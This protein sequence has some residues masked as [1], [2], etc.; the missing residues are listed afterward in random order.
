[1]ASAQAASEGITINPQ[2]F[3]PEGPLADGE[4][5]YYAEMG[6][7]RVMR[8][9]GNANRLIWSRPGC[10]PTSV[11]RAGRDLIVLCHIEE[12]LVRISVA[13]ETLQVI[14]RDRDGRPFMTPNASVNDRKGG[15]YFSSS[16]LF[17]SAAP[18]QGAVL[19]LDSSGRLS[20]LAEGV[21]YSNGVALTPDGGTLYVSEHLS[22]R[23][24]AYDVAGDGRLFGRRVFVALD[25]LVGPEDGRGWEV[26]PDGLAVD[27]AGNV[28][29]AEYGAGRLLIVDRRGGLLATV[30]VPERYVTAPALTPDETRIYLTAPASLFDPAEAGRVYAIANPVHRSQ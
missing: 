5:V 16:G 4:G 7:D 21:R 29:V 8:W 19:Y 15:V 12:S 14:D 23:V 20:R 18:A 24:L 27:S 17:S 13:G 30:A 3:Y 26:G 6:S 28:Y 10:G 2:A 9:D 22:R 25:D 1:M 11:A